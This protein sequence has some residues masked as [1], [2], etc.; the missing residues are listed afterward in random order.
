[1]FNRFN[2]A[3]CVN[4]II[5]INSLYGYVEAN[6]VFRNCCAPQTCL[7]FVLYCFKQ[8]LRIYCLPIVLLRP[9]GF[10]DS[11]EVMRVYIGPSYV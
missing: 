2:C 11:R 10:T 3:C 4:R 6:V 8:L 9:V 1:L 7:R 5:N